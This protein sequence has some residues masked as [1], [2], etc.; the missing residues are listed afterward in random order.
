MAK[1]SKQ[2]KRERE[3][4]KALLRDPQPAREVLERALSLGMGEALAHPALPEGLLPRFAHL[5]LKGLP[6]HT[7]PERVRFLLSFWLERDPVALAHSPLGGKALPELKERLFAKGDPHLARALLPRLTPQELEALAS[8]P[9]EEVR[10]AVAEDRYPPRKLL[11]DPSPRVRLAALRTLDPLA[12]A[13]EANPETAACVEAW[14]EEAEERAFAFPHPWPREQEWEALPWSPEG[15]EALVLLSRWAK[16]PRLQGRYRQALYDLKGAVLERWVGE[17]RAVPLAVLRGKDPRTEV[18]EEWMGIA[19]SLA[20]DD[21]EMALHDL[22]S[23]FDC[24]STARMGM[25]PAW[26]WRASGR[27]L[28]PKRASL[29]PGV[30]KALA[31]WNEKGMGPLSLV[32]SPEDFPQGENLPRYGFRLGWEDLLPSRLRRFHP[33]GEDLAAFRIEGT[34]TVLHAPYVE[35]AHLLPADLE[36]LP[37]E[38]YGRPP[39]AEEKEAWPLERVLSL[40]TPAPRRDLEDILR[41]VE[42]ALGEGEGREEK[43]IGD[44]DEDWDED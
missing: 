33:R 13:L 1:L 24:K 40:L 41:A 20:A 38:E 11:E 8:H 12:Y 15:A 29:L 7:P 9:E 43:E 18:D 37:R 26:I 21:L 14:A 3:Y 28:P 34:E 39:T 27:P 44:W 42:E 19:A 23:G 2:A 17:G 16:L 6:P 5:A 30:E 32:L 22:L 35:M 31:L 25:G 10:L 4:L 36:E